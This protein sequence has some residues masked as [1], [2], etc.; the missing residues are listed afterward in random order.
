MSITMVVNQ[1]LTHSS[2]CWR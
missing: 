1:I 2:S